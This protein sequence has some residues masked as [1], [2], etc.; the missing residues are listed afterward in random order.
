M[1]FN[2]NLNKGE[3]RGYAFVAPGVMVIALLI[4]YPI[5]AVIYLS[6]VRSGFNVTEF[7]GLNN[8]INVFQS[9]QFAQ[10]IKNTFIWTSGTVVLAFLLGTGAAL[11]LNQDFVK[12]P[13]LWRAVL[14]LSWII[15]GVVKA[16]VWK[17]L[18]SYDFGMFNHLLERVGVI[19][20]PVGWLSNTNLVMGTVILVQI[21]ATFPFA[22]LM[23]SAGLQSIPKELSE[24]AELDGAAGLTKF[25]YIFMPLLKDVA[26]I[27]ILILIIWSLNE[28]ALIWIITQGGPAGSSQILSLSIYD[29]FR[30][31]NINGAA[32]TAVLQLSISL[33][34]AVCYV[35][36]AKKEV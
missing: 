24:V 20:Q 19:S 21:W 23:I 18:Y 13:G 2:L 26:F 9:H 17:W 30:S 11:L 1:Q 8:F 16:T 10:I 12:L 31:F 15:P 36:Q 25:Y 33:V 27:T 3:S 14:M 6:F 28:F 35:Y 5:L 22:M 29:K 34:F 4:I 32:A 7:V